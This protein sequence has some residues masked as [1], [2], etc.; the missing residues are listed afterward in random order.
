M[1]ETATKGSAADTDAMVG[2]KAVAKKLFGKHQ[3]KAGPILNERQLFVRQ[4]ARNAI[5]GAKL[6]I[7]RI[8]QGDD[9]SSEAIEACTLLAGK[10]ATLLLGV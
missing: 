3:R 1:A 7:K 9:V 5:K 2:A 4:T 8:E 10:T 6:I